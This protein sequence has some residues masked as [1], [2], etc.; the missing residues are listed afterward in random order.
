[1]KRTLEAKLEVAQN[2]CIRFSY[3]FIVSYEIGFSETV[4]LALPKGTK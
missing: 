1:M 4:K 2:N 3:G